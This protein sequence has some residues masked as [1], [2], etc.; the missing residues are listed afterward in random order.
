[1][2]GQPSAAYE[3]AEI[4]R[5]RLTA[6]VEAF[7]DAVYSMTL[8]GWITHWNSSA[9]QLYGYSNAEMIGQ[10]FSTLLPK[11]R[12]LE[13]KDLLAAA[14][15]NA[16]IT[17]LETL[18]LTKAGG[19][20]GVSLRVLPVLDI[21][22]QVTG[23]S[24]IARNISERR[25]AQEEHDRF[26]TLSLDMLC[27]AGIDGYF[28]KLSPAWHKTL[29]YSEEELLAVPLIEFVHP[30][31]R[32]TTLDSRKNIRQGVLTPNFENRYRC[33]DGSYRRLRWN[34]VSDPEMGLMYGVAHDITE[35]K[36]TEDLI[37]EYTVA[38]EL[39]KQQL[40][41]AN[42]ELAKLAM[43]DGL[44]GLTNHRAFHERLAEEVSQAN[45]YGT[46]LSLTL[47]DVD[48]FKLYNDQHGHPAGDLV[49]QAVAHILQGCARENDL[50][51]RYGGEEF[52]LILPMTEI[53]GAAAFAERLRRAIEG[54]SWPLQAVTA[55]F[56]VA[57]LRP[58]TETGAELL[59]SSDRALYQS[60]AEGRNRVTCASSSSTPL[61]AL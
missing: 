40:E 56:G 7:D 11:E 33:R 2:N 19:F 14:A 46:P 29:G 45:R 37:K 1:M 12:L 9:E 60:K 57:T 26:F 25:Q 39:Q 55:S 54:H 49:L 20:M 30:E 51:A 41:K 58:N 13:M 44:T 34:T 35:Q 48:Y 23:A 38:L 15:C 31:D 61:E 53:D 10:P 52:A 24:V 21:Q 50:V 36:K 27:I 43:T 4:E 5:L 18:H 32:A 47:L 8:E 6:I 28:K 17:P 59:V 3:R 16:N 42:A 22:G